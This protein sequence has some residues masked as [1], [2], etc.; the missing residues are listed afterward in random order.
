LR[1]D[2]SV[3]IRRVIATVAT[4]AL[5]ASGLVAGTA[6]AAVAAP[7]SVG[8]HG[9]T[10]FTPG[11]YIVTLV[12]ASAATYEGGVDGFAPTKPDDGSQLR[13][14]RRAVQSYSD[15]L[16]ERQKDVAASVGAKIDYSYTLALNGFAA[17]LTA[18]QAMELAANK[19]VAA[20]APD[21]LRHV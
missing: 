17:T 18:K 10:A 8:G 3:S 12:D 1:R 14:E 16:T 5:I 21:E 7:A 6:L 19:D 4:S 9:Q 20:L 13:A 11:R 2:T 15:Y